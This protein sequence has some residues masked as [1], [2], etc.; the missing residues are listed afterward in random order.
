MTTPPASAKFQDFD[1][2]SV[3]DHFK[4]IVRSPNS[5]NFI[6]D[7]DSTSAQ[8]AFDLDEQGV[9]DALQERAS[10]QEVREVLESFNSVLV[11]S[12]TRP[13]ETLELDG[14]TFLP[15]SHCDVAD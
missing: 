2:K 9:K 14:C 11:D 10:Q 6:L 15:S 12:Y 7:F 5:N 8:C 3:F 4:N 13:V 1:Q